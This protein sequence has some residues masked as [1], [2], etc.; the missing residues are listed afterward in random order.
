[1][2][3]ISS[4]VNVV[5]GLAFKSRTIFIIGPQQK[6]KHFIRLILNYPAAVGI[7]N[8]VLRAVDALQAADYARFDDKFMI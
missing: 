5:T 7:S 1:V 3:K 8:E 4:A 2:E 6:G